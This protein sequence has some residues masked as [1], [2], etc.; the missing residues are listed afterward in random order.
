MPKYGD[1][2]NSAH[3]NKMSARAQHRIVEKILKDLFLSLESIKNRNMN[4]MK[5]A[6]DRFI[7]TR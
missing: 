6:K 4:D 2:D 5:N 3:K 7:Y 1:A